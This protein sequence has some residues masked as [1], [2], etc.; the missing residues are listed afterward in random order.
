MGL[1]VS[2]S[3]QESWYTTHPEHK[4]H[5]E[6]GNDQ[7]TTVFKGKTIAE[8]DKVL[9]LRE[10]QHGPVYYFPRESVL[11][12]Y[13]ERTDHHTY[14]PFKGEASYWTIRVNGRSLENAVWS[15]EDPF[16]E[17]ASIKDYVA[18]YINKMD[19][20]YANGEPLDPATA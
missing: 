14:C 4:I 11:M 18:F 15:Y 20:W 12:G 8:S 13:L 17:V 3:E 10:S 6:I 2:G 16:V 5:V 7:I 19:S 1:T 9:V